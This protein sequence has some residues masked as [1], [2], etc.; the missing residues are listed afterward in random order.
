M[1]TSL[2]D[3]LYVGFFSSDCAC[4]TEE[5]ELFELKST[6][7]LLQNLYD[8]VETLRLSY[9]SQLHD[10]ISQAKNIINSDK[11]ISVTKVE[12]QNP[13]SNEK[14]SFFHQALLRGYETEIANLKKEIERVQDST[15]FEIEL[16]TAFVTEEKDRLTREVTS[17]NKSAA[18]FE[19]QMMKKDEQMKELRKELSNLNDRLREKT[20]QAKK[21]TP[22]E[23]IIRSVSTR[24]ITIQTDNLSPTIE[25]KPTSN[26][27][28]AV[29]Q[30]KLDALETRYKTFMEQKNNQIQ[31]LNN[32]YEVQQKTYRQ[33]MEKYVTIE[34]RLQSDAKSMN[35]L[36]DE[37]Y[38]RQTNIRDRFVAKP[39]VVSYVSIYF[40]HTKRIIR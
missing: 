8:A 26:M 10:F 7:N 23:P 9:R 28:E 27:S 22:V 3:Q 37:M 12:K 18:Q 17:L 38:T 29:M 30:E 24:S 33:K 21:V 40:N 34:E 1:T 13:E 6:T 4:Q 32:D 11:P 20:Q 15:K 35:A 14:L 16:A 19:D 2:T 36:R 25:Q 31:Q 5:T 39:A